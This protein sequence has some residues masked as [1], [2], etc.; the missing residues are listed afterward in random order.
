MSVVTAARIDPL[1]DA[2][3]GASPGAAE[4]PPS[5]DGRQAWLRAVALGG[6]GRYAAA[7]AELG[8]VRAR[9]GG[10]AN[11]LSL[12]SSTE[13]S[14]LRQV[15]FHALATEYDGVAVRV[16][17]APYAVADAL[18][19]LAADALGQ[20]RFALSSRLLT[21]ATDCAEQAGLR[22]RIRLRWVTAELA[23]ATGAGAAAL[24]SAEAAVELAAASPS[25][26]HRV[27]SAL[28]RAAALGCCGDVAAAVAAAGDVIEHCREQR[29]TPLRW[30]AG[31][32]CAGMA[33]DPDAAADAAADA[34]LCAAGVARRSSWFRGI[35]QSF[36]PEPL[37]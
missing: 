33:S 14:F 7:R 5:R 28:L 6:Q 26:R 29:L 4:L 12:A 3:F 30:A 32:L 36:R 16:G 2:A 15:G 20:G 34:A 25:V 19:G 23:M 31:M 17:K 13:A 10:D 27:K 37:G 9:A 21:R 11:L 18:T 22:Q 8:L 1:L 35:H 24:A